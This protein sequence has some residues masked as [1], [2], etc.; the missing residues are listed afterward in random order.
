MSKRD[1]LVEE[2]LRSELMLKAHLKALR[3]ALQQQLQE[4]RRRQTEE[5]DERIH[6]NTLLSTDTNYKFAERRST[7]AS[8]LISYEK[9]SHYPSQRPNVFSH[10]LV[11]SLNP[12]HRSVSTQ[13]CEKCA[14]SKTTQQ[15]KEEEAEAECR[16][17]FSAAPVPSCVTQPVYRE[18]MELR[19]KERKR[20]HEQRKLLLLSSQKP[21]SF[22]QRD[23]KT[24]EKMSAK[25]NQ[26]SEDPKNSFRVQKTSHIHLKGS[27]EQK[28][29][30]ELC[31][32]LQ[33]QIASKQHAPSQAGCLKLR[34]ADHTK[35]KK[36]GFLDEQPSFKPK[37]IPQVP[38]FKRLH[39]AL[40]REA[41]E[42][43]QSRDVT[44]CQPFVLKTSALPA[45][46]SMESPETPQVSKINNLSRSKSLG[47]LTLI[48]RDTLPTYITDAARQRC[49]AIRKSIEVRESK[50]QE[51][52]EWLKSHQMRSQAMKRT[53]ALH[54]KLLD[55]HSSLKDVCKE[56]LQR[57]READLEKVRNYMRELRDMK[58]RVT[59]RPYLFEQVKQNAKAQ[60]E[61]TYRRKLQKVGIKEQFVEETGE[62][63]RYDYADTSTSSHGSEKEIQSR[64]ENVDD[65][66]KI[67][68]VEEKSVKSKAEEMP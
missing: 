35:E 6:R 21:F 38:D 49:A 50:N 60:A 19:E 32:N 4:T 54:A 56:N 36:L 41:L 25:L 66:E 55:P 23:Q 42:K 64:E 1:T 40:Q 30:Q 9:A 53:V 63:F 37:I 27:K 8:A 3:M 39:R 29:L 5:L 44:R 15:K 18:M 57:H 13:Q 48:S 34:I 12:K 26:G 43:K 47:A 28:D 22:E 11:P 59:E 58:A 2:G 31:R 10:S 46:K 16:K 14:P 62:S 24:R 20:G 67:E 33:T 68:D 51:S 52:A 45:R 17:K 65:G 7:P 61:Q